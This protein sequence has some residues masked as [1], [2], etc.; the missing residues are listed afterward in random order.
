MI[1]GLACVLAVEGGICHR[2]LTV[3]VLRRL[4]PPVPAA[5]PQ[6]Q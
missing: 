1:A 6:E 5:L 3:P 2:A 4:A